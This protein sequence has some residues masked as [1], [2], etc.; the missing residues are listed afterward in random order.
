LEV[1][2]GET[3]HIYTSGIP[4]GAETHQSFFRSTGSSSCAN[5]FGLP[6]VA[7]QTQ[8]FSWDVVYVGSSWLIGVVKVVAAKLYPL[9]SKQHVNDLCCMGFMGNLLLTDSK[10]ILT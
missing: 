1:C 3:T 2:K 10:K 8:V 9:K 6:S 7:K 4:Q 5:V